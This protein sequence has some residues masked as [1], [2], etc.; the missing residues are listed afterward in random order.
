MMRVRDFSKG[1]LFSGLFLITGVTAR[2]QALQQWGDSRLD[3]CSEELQDGGDFKSLSKQVKAELKARDSESVYLST[4][5]KPL[6]KDARS[7]SKS[8]NTSTMSD[9]DR[10]EI[11]GMMSPDTSEKVLDTMA[12]RNHSGKVTRSYDL[13]Y[14]DGKVLVWPAFWVGGRRARVTLEPIMKLPA[15]KLDP[16]VVQVLKSKAPKLSLD[17]LGSGS[18]VAQINSKG[19]YEF[20]YSADGKLSDMGGLEEFFDKGLDGLCA[21]R[22]ENAEQARKQSRLSEKKSVAAPQHK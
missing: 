13:Q 19:V 20:G 8:F 4:A 7:Y 5:M 18:S 9:L 2:A 21:H 6:L 10:Y 17:G 14:Q 3:L 22:A 11:A 15:A 1:F 16:E 12:S